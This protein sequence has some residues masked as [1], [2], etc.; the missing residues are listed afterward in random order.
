MAASLVLLVMALPLWMAPSRDDGSLDRALHDAL[1]PPPSGNAVLV[2]D[3][4]ALAVD[5]GRQDVRIYLIQRLPPRPVPS[6]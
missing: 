1:L 5:S 2:H 3:G 6:Q 4:A